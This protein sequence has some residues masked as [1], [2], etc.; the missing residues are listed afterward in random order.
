MMDILEE[1]IL[2]LYYDHPDKWVEIMKNAMSEVE[3]DFDSGR[4][5]TEYYERMFT[6]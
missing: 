2:P 1:K 5:V 4:M 3:I 6:I